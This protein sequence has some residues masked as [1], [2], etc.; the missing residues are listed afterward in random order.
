MKEM[1]IMSETRLTVEQIIADVNQLEFE[2]FTMLNKYLSQLR[3]ERMRNVA[4]GKKRQLSAELSQQKQSESLHSFTGFEDGVHRM[5]QTFKQ[6]GS[7]TDSLSL[8]EQLRVQVQALLP[9]AKEQ[10]DPRRHLLAMLSIAL[11]RTKHEPLNGEKRLALEQI[12]EKLLEK[13]PSSEEVATLRRQ[14]AL[15]GIDVL[16]SFGKFAD[17]LVHLANADGPPAE[18]RS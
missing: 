12:A 10:A 18:G 16:P 1:K 8:Q 13:E 15:A 11:R 2:E 14:L 4:D 9:L 6:F 5:V 17:G 7:N 3:H